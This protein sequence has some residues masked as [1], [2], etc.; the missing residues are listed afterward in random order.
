MHHPGP[1]SRSCVARFTR[2]EKSGRG[3]V[4]ADRWVHSTWAYRLHE[5]RGFVDRLADPVVRPTTA[6]VTDR[7]VETVVDRHAVGLCL[8]DL[9]D[10]RHDLAGLA[11]AALGDVP[12]QPCRLHRV[13]PS[14]GTRSEER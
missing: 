12:L 14:A 9:G 7:V 6:H 4:I 1:S 8:L 5:L 13:E 11:V 3:G 2:A 10:R